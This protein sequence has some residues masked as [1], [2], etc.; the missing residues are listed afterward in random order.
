MNVNFNYIPL[1]KR[2]NNY[3][4]NGTNK[5][6]IG[7]EI[8]ELVCGYDSLIDLLPSQD[9]IAIHESISLNSQRIPLSHKRLKQFILD[10]FDLIQFNIPKLSRVAILLPNGPE[11]AVTL[12][13]V[14]SQCYCAAPIN[15]TNTWQEI[16]SELESTKC[17]VIII[18][19]G[20]SSNNESA[21]K[22]ASELGIGIITIE[23]FGS[24]TG[25][26]HMK[27]LQPVKNYLN[28]IHPINNKIEGFISYDHPETVLLLH[29]SGTSGNKK[30][31]PY[32]LD[33]ILVGVGCI[34]SSWDLTPQDTCLNMMPLF[35]IGGIIRNIFSPILSGNHS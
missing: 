18:M 8:G 9:N 21:I 6:I 24:I 27:L 1:L 32:S 33:M 7:H 30:L 25:L 22:A 17:V 31:V 3:G 14:V 16:K 26:F 19:S 4:R 2:L 10:E 5:Q 12:L 35:H 13:C 28:I 23:S 29:T 15:L 34:V 11:L 20:A